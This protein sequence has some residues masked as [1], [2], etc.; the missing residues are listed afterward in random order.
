MG[1][2]LTRHLDCPLKKHGIW[3]GSGILDGRQRGR[4]GKREQR[5]RHYTPSQGRSAR[6]PFQTRGTRKSIE[7]QLE[8]RSH[9]VGHF[10]M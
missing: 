2:R 3:T 10:V 4:T 6:T 9:G 5:R 7:V 1:A 8:L